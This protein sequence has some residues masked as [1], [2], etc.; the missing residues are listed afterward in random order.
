MY[1][2]YFDKKYDQNNMVG[3]ITDTGTVCTIYNIQDFY[4]TIHYF[5]QFAKRWLHTNLPRRRFF[6][7]FGDL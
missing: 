7:L 1:V 3:H 2:L 4:N 5:A 6:F